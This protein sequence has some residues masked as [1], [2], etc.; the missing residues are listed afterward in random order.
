MPDAIRQPFC[1]LWPY[2]ICPPG[3]RATLLRRKMELLRRLQKSWGWGED[4]QELGCPPRC[5]RTMVRSR[6][7]GGAGSLAHWPPLP[8]ACPGVNHMSPE[9]RSAAPLGL[10][11]ALRASLFTLTPGADR[12]CLSCLTS[13]GTG[14]CRSGER[15]VQKGSEAGGPLKWAL[16]TVNTVG[17]TNSKVSLDIPECCGDCWQ[18]LDKLGPCL[19]ESLTS[20][21]NFH[22]M[23]R[24]KLASGLAGGVREGFLEGLRSK[25]DAPG[26]GSRSQVAATAGHRRGSL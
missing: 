19:Q 7:C 26:R 5:P 22:T 15:S 21:S 6:A 20:R 10:P 24:V 18:A 17:Q 3:G 1:D 2:H 14:A 16:A 13:P 12:R 11:P 9:A 25:G 23:K 8:Y 4:S